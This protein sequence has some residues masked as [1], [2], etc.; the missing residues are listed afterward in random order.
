MHVLLCMH[1]ISRETGGEHAL[2]MLLN[3][4]SVITVAVAAEPRCL[5]LS[6]PHML[7]YLSSRKLAGKQ[8]KSLDQQC[9]SQ[10]K[11]LIPKASLVHPHFSSCL[12]VH[13]SSL[14]KT[15]DSDLILA[16]IKAKLTNLLHLPILCSSM[17]HYD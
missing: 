6:H 11:I 7:C 5:C 4:P 2:L 9:P 10:L 12:A 8:G 3:L 16:M 1:M 13:L 17:K 15:Q 14:Q